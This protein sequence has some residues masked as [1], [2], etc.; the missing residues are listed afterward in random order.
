MSGQDFTATITVDQTPEE[1][2]AAIN[3]VRGW[4]SEEVEGGTEKIGDEFVF[5]VQDVHYCKMKLTEVVPGHKVVWQVSDSYI[6]FVEDKAEWD[7]TEILF[8][9]SEK[10][11]KT[12]VCF[13]HVGLAPAVE[14]YD[15]CSD[16]W[17]SY[18]TGSLRSL[19][20]TGKGDPYRKA[21]TFETEVAK[22]QS[23]KE[24]A[25]S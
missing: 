20:A 9:V 1:A 18:V 4:W 6:A 3:N 8:E 13:T 2:F 10:D 24:K 15:V 16:A 25:S 17:R 11:G 12:E 22:H 21:G 14:C 5:H 7:D 23:T 19:I